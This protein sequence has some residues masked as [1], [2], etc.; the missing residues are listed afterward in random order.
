M[1]AELTYGDRRALVEDA[2][3]QRVQA[4]SGASHCWLYVVDMTDLWA[5]YV[6]EGDDTWQVT[7][8]IDATGLTTLG[9]PVEVRKVSSYELV[10]ATSMTESAVMATDR[11]AGRV[12]ESTHPTGSRV[13]RVRI[14]A[15][16]DSKNGRRYPEAVMAAAVPL[17]EGSKAFDHH[18]SPSELDTSTVQGLVGTYRNV[19][20]TSEGIDADFH[21]LP[22]AVQVAEALDQSLANQASGLG[23]LV[24]FSHDVIATFK[25]VTDPDGNR[26]MEA[27]QI[28]SVLSADVVADPAAGGQPTRV[29]AGGITTPQPK[30]SLVSKPTDGQTAEPVGGSTTATLVAPI[31]A[32]EA[33]L[34]VHQTEAT[35]AKGGLMASTLIDTALATVANAGL[36]AK[37]AES[38]T[39]LLPDRF[40]E[41]QV[42]AT[43]A[44]V[45]D[46]ASRFEVAGLG[47]VVGHDPKVTKDVQDRKTEALDKMMAGESGGY[48]SLRE[49]YRDISGQMP[50]AI[51][52]EDEARAILRACRGSAHGYDSAARESAARESVTAA[53]FDQIMGDSIT[54]RLIAEYALPQL[55]SWRSI[56]SAFATV[57][58][59]RTN[60][61]Q[62]MGGYGLLPVVGERAPYQP[63]VTPGDEEA[64]YAIAK[65]GGTEDLTLEAIANDDLGAVTAIPLKLARA[66]AQTLYRFVWDMLATNATCTYDATALFHANHANTDAASPLSQTAMGV[67]RKKM[68][69]QSAFGD[70]SDVLFIAPRYLIVPPALEELAFQ[71][72]ASA[73]AIPATPAGPSNTPNIN[74]GVMPIV[75]PYL[76]DQDDWFVVADPKMVPTIEI[77]FYR[78]Q[79]EP[80]LFVQDDPKNGSWFDADVVTYKIRHIYSGT[81]LDHRGF[82]RGV[83]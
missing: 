8:S 66:A 50:R 80:E 78:G 54:R 35:F 62:R 77:G 61:R 17:Y 51:S 27:T 34:T 2:I 79:Q 19:I 13:F 33:V 47:P 74:Q 16:G 56:V 67:A 15:Y 6:T 10:G 76:T 70:A 44:T 31:P 36:R 26:L 38:V 42:L 71:L 9:D 37:L 28:V 11:V 20:A 32:T 53:T 58:D 7:Y 43:A 24:G 83:V 57:N 59:F 73:V 29:V 81:L 49:A 14:L 3:R 22:S 60:K 55:Q 63:L 45:R 41:A 52:G 21:V 48:R 25:P 82:Y 65:R 4:L 40:T 39:G 68:G 72:T 46:M 12:L 69:V 5:V 30:E 18:R 23:P 1:P 64:T 75:V